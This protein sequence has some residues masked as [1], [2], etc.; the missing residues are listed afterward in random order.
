MWSNFKGKWPWSWSNQTYEHT[1]I[2]IFAHLSTN[3]NIQGLNL[4]S[5]KPVKTAL[6]VKAISKECIHNAMCDIMMT[7]WSVVWPEFRWIFVAAQLLKDPNEENTLSSF[8]RC[9]YPLRCSLSSWITSDLFSTHLTHSSSNVW[10]VFS[11]L[12]QMTTLLL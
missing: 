2:T 3:H 8:Q 7:P 6:T 4:L 5:S 9:K 11:I 12:E 1:A 10:F